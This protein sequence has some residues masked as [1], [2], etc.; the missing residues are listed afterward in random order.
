MSERSV[1]LEA[2]AWG[3]AEAGSKEGVRQDYKGLVACETF[4]IGVE[5]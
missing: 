4:S 2:D 1:R 5:S 3:S